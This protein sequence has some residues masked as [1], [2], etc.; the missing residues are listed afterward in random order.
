ML[1]ITIPGRDLTLKLKN[2]ILDLNGTLTLDGQLLHGVKTAV[3][4]LKSGLQIY[5]LTSDTLGCGASAAE[6]LGIEIF[7]VGSEQSGAD[8]LDFLNTVGAEESIVIGNGYNDRL[9]LECAALSIAV[10]GPEGCCAQAL[11]KADL[12]VT[13]IQTA[14][15]LIRTPLRIVATLRD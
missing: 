9:I 8:K 10:I 7:K 3:E 15:D 12:V 14:L 2:L 1:E 11:Q 6:E 13:D 5:L 4:E